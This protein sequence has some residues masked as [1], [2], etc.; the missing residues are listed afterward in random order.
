MERR[1]PLG[2]RLR[3][4][5]AANSPPQLLS[6][7]NVER[8][9]L[10]FW[11]YRCYATSNNLAG[12][13]KSSSR[14]QVTIGNDDGRVPWGQ[15]SVG[16]K[17]ARTTQQTFNFGVILAGAVGLVRT[18]LLYIIE[19]LIWIRLLLPTISIS[20]SS[21]PTAKSGTSIAPLIGSEPT[22]VHYV[23]L[24]LVTQLEH[25]ENP[26]QASGLGTDQLRKQGN[27]ATY[28]TENLRPESSSNTHTD[29]T[30][31]EHFQMHFNVR[32]G[33]P[34]NFYLITDRHS[35]RLWVRNGLEL[36]IYIWWKARATQTGAIN[37]SLLMYQVW[38]LYLLDQMSF[39]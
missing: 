16:E 34:H 36:W 12:T 9:G 8:R 4:A 1:I 3:A 17:A 21:L 11:N 38:A 6:F 24:G 30:G 27:P 29:R 31:I 26:P 23:C 35:V 22:L 32:Q 25:L 14:K 10:P 39:P 2:A 19:L 13:T 37:F 28:H 33:A 5:V 15:L 18:P 20:T 7:K